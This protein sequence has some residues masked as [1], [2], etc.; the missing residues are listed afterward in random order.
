MGMETDQ[1]A[2]D[3]APA[4][5]RLRDVFLRFSF[6]LVS[7]VTVWVVTWLAIAGTVGLS[8]VALTLVIPSGVVVLFALVV[9]RQEQTWVWPVK[10]INQMLPR[11]RAGELPIES[12]GEIDGGL[13]ELASQVR[14]VLRELR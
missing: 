11:I 13:A 1:I 14:D 4:A 10:R 9:L 6:M 8:T 2:P 5:P 3:D 12:L 7:A